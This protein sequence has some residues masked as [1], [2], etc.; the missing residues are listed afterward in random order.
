MANELAHSKSPYLLQHA[1][2]PVNWKPW[3]DDIFELAKRENK[4]IFISIGY[5]A[6]HWC[7]VMEKESFTNNDIAGLINKHFIPV[8]IDR[9]ERPD[10]DQ[11]YMNAVQIM[12]GQG[13]WPLSCFALPDGTPFFGGTYFPPKEFEGILQSLVATWLKESHRILEAARQ[14]KEGLVKTDII[15]GDVINNNKPDDAYLHE[16]INSWE[17]QFDSYWGGNSGSPKFPLPASLSFLLN[18]G[19][20]YKASNI[21][22]HVRLTLER[23]IQGGIHDHIGGGFARYATDKKWRV[24]HFEKMLYDNGQILNLLADFYK[25]EPSEIIEE[26][27][28]NTAGF[29]KQNMLAENHGFYSSWDADSEGE[30]GKFYVWT[31]DEIRNHLGQNADLFIEYYNIQKAGNWENGKNIL[32]TETPLAA[33][34]KNH[35]INPTEGKKIIKD[36]LQTLKQ[37]RSNRVKP[38]LDNKQLASWNAMAIEGLLNSFQALNKNEW[39]TIAQNA[40]D[41]L[42]KHAISENGSIIR[43]CRKDEH[44]IPGLLEEYAFTIRT[45]VKL[46]ETTADDKWLKTTKKLL[47]YTRKNFK[48]PDSAMFFQAEKQNT[49]L[50]MRKMEIMDNVIPSANSVMAQNLYLFSVLDETPDYQEQSLQMLRNMK[51]KIQHKGPFFSNWMQ[52]WLWFVNPPFEIVVSGTQARLKAEKLQQY[53]L[54]A[55][56]LVWKNHESDLPVFKNRYAP[57][58]TRIFICRNNIC[59]KPLTIVGDVLES[60]GISPDNH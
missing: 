6:C 2:N 14:V 39:L 22:E 20:R 55:L 30:E 51:S 17:F 45:M 50:G 59:Q 43:N 57:D 31:I 16:F 5:A 44:A 34:C 53:Y 49:P 26:A 8:K 54:P 18:Y 42:I 56:L 33:V 11:I 10:V 46:F 15:K 9:E 21:T 32:Y 19:M 29:L 12:T 52:L 25:F 7:H 1:N 24:P 28:T 27:I 3:S 37:V 58:E 38:A 40:G 13:G 35:N 4:M 60:M 41:F 36:A 23:M 47:S 48:D